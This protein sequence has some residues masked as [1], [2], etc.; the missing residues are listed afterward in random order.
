[1]QPVNRKNFARC[2]IFGALPIGNMPVRPESGDTVIAADKG[3]L[4]LKEI[5]IC[6]DSVIGDFD[7]LGYIP[8]GEN[9]TRLPVEKDDTDV[10]FAVKTALGEGC[11]EIFVY[12][13]LGG[14]LDHTV[15]NLQL[16]AMAAEQGAA[17]FFFGED[18]AVTAVCGGSALFTPQC[19]GRLSVFCIGE[20]AAGVTIKGAKYTLS[21]ARLLPSFPLGVSNEFTGE[22]AEI[23]VKSG[24]LLITFQPRKAALPIVKQGSAKI[25]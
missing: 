23:S 17:P 24:T 7:S 15:A 6:P 25:N 9:I 19:S 21:G 5:G 20:P 22:S 2:F 16:A 3:L 13:A 1:M 4:R 10:G 8:Q 11:K 12:G 18:I 14:K